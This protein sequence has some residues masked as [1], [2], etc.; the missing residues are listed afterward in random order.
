[1]CF[2]L[3]WHSLNSVDGYTEGTV[4]EVSLV[5]KRP[6]TCPRHLRS[7]GADVLWQQHRPTISEEPCTSWTPQHLTNQCRFIDYS[8]YTQL[9][10]TYQVHLLWTTYKQEHGISTTSAHQQIMLYIG[11]I[12]SKIM[13]YI[14]KQDGTNFAIWVQSHP[15]YLTLCSANV[16]LS[17][18]SR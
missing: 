16:K 18:K 6:W 4:S 2:E 9:T 3:T 10:N 5:S 8:F 1:M 17:R 12:N 7:T 15:R 13:L 11:N 14:G